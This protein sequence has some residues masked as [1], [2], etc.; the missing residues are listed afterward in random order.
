MQ[1]EQLSP[2]FN[3]SDGVRIFG[4]SL[5]SGP[6]HLLVHGL[7]GASVDF[8]P[9]LQWMSAYGTVVAIDLRGHGL[10]DHPEDSGAYS[11]HRMASDLVEVVDLLGL[12]LH[13][14]IGHSMGGM[15]V[16]RAILDL[17]LPP[18]RLVLFN[19][20]GGPLPRITPALADAGAEV[21]KK[22]GVPGFRSLMERLDPLG[23]PAA[24]HF[25]STHPEYAAV[26]D[27]RWEHISAVMYAT[28]ISEIARLPD[29][30][31]R[32]SAIQCPT[33]IMVGEEDLPFVGPSNALA[34][35]IP[36]ARFVQLKDAGHQAQLHQPKEWERHVRELLESPAR[37]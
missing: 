16:R 8:D 26:Q 6:L 23:T 36:N 2:Q 34:A 32:M 13:C 3:M 14:L 27:W 37:P 33:L 1:A 10:S 29:E 20:T 22:E 35:A 25:R 15:V 21:L 17:G 12:D 31:A 4:K 28:M 7:G 11:L 5:G 24:A 18:Q 9:H 30:N 19:T